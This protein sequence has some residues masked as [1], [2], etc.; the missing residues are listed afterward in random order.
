MTQFLWISIDIK[1]S[2]TDYDSEVRLM[3]GCKSKQHFLH[4][5][6]KHRLAAVGCSAKA[7]VVAGG[8]W[9][10][11]TTVEVMDMDTLKWSSASCLLHG[12]SDASATACGDRVPGWRDCSERTFNKDSP[13]LLSECPPPVT[14]GE[15]KEPPGVVHTC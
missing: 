5:P 4:M 6:T 15:N 7:L 12:L 1:I 3:K 2:L 13:Q 8:G 11:L 9:T 10:K 14:D